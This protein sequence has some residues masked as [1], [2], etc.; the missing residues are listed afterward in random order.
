[1]TEVRP[2]VRAYITMMMLGGMMGPMT[3]EAAVMAPA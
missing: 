2:S 1:M 3:A